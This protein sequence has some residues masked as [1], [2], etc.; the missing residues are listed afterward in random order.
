MQI[1]IPSRDG[2]TGENLAMLQAVYSR[3]AASVTEHLERVRSKGSDNFMS[4]YYL[5]YGHQSIGD[6]ATETVFIED[7]SFLAAKALQDSPLY[8]GQESSTRYIDFRTRPFVDPI[9]TD[10]SAEVLEGW[11][12]IYI[13]VYDA[14]KADLEDKYFQAMQGSEE[15]S[16]VQANAI[17]AKACDV[18]RGFLPLGGTTQLAYSTTLRQ[19]G[20]RLALLDAHPL[21][22]VRTIAAEVRSQLRAQHPS[23]FKAVDYAERQNFYAQTVLDLHYSRISDFDSL[24]PKDANPDYF[25]VGKALN[26]SL[27]NKLPSSLYKNRPAKTDLPRMLASLGSMSF[28]FWMDYGSFRD[29]QRHRNGFCPIPLVEGKLRLH[30][31]YLAQIP[32][33]IRNHVEKLLTRQQ[34]LFE[35][36]QV[37]TLGLSLAELQYYYPLAQLVPVRLIYDV[38]QIAYVSELR[39]SKH[40][41]PT[42]RVV[43]LRMGAAFGKELPEIPLHLDTSDLDAFN[44]DRGTQTFLQAQ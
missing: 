40:V 39:S 9:G 38:P 36:F 16:K 6:C 19:F 17:H 43:A 8:N 3:S 13:A 44:L 11:R 22:E 41:H 35:K 25:N 26:K 42:C 14:V 32:Y 15:I 7:I 2:L 20:D 4:T 27:L 18:A 31:W 24:D 12:S 28:E 5:N 23:S 33:Q 10:L 37:K 21:T 1:I 34:E 29:I 30:L